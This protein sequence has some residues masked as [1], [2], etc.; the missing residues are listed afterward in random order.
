V[1]ENMPWEKQRSVLHHI[2]KEWLNHQRVGG[3]ENGEFFVD[4]YGNLR[5][6]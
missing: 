4:T 6:M 2:S 1:A 3:F 5:P